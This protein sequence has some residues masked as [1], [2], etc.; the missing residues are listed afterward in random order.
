MDERGTQRRARTSRACEQLLCG[1]SLFFFDFV[2]ALSR[3]VYNSAPV[4]NETFTEQYH[5]NS[6]FDIQNR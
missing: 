6:A 3:L 4:V 2:L 1:C 5:E